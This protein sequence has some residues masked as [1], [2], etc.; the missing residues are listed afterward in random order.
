MHQ[1]FS[2]QIWCINT[3]QQYQC[4][5]AQWLPKGIAVEN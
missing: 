4:I 5:L 1:E 2:N 3:D